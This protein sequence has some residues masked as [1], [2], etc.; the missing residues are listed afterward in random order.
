MLQYI[1]YCINFM[2]E[3]VDDRLKLA[4]GFLS[5]KLDVHF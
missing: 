1:A 5:F 4:V 3:L 2:N